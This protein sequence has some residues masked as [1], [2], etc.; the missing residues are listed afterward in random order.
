MSTRG[1]RR[2]LPLFVLGIFLSA[3]FPSKAQTPNTI[4]T[5]A[6]GGANSTSA[7]AA[8]LPG[9]TAAVRDT[10]GNTYV[11]VP[12]LNVVY[13]INSLGQVSI[14][15]GTGL[16]G[17]SGDGG[18]AA[19][20]QLNDPLSL[21]VDHQG[22]LFISDSSNNRIRRVDATTG[23]ITTYAGSGDQYNGV[24]FFGGYSGDDGP[25]TSALLNLPSGLAFDGNE[26]LF[27]ADAGNEV[28]RRI[29]NS[30]QHII[31]TYA[32]N[33]NAGVPGTANGD[34]GPAASAQLNAY[35][36]QI[37]G[38]ATDA[39][40]NLFIADSGDSVVRMVDTS[41]SHIITTYAGS[42]SHTF[43]F[44]GNGGSAN[45]AG[46]NTPMG[47]FVDNAG[48]LLIA[49]TFNGIVRKVDTTPS[50]IITTAVGGSGEC[51]TF[52][53][54][55]GNGGAPTGAALNR[56]YGVFVDSPGNLLIADF[57][58][59]TIRA[60]SPAP[61]SVISTFAGGGN[62][63]LGGAATSALLALPYYV[64][65]DSSGNL[66]VQDYVGVDRFDASSKT[67]GAYAGNSSISGTTFGPGNGDNGPANQ[68]DFVSPSTLALDG[69]GD[70]FVNE[71]NRWV[72][73]VDGATK[74]VTTYA[75][76]GLKCNPTAT[77]GCGDGG[78]AT[79]AT[80][81]NISGMAA[82]SGGNLYVADSAQ[83]RIRRI[84]KTTGVISNYAGTGAA[85][86]SGDN[87]PATSATF[88]TPFG[89][90]FDAQDDLYVADAANNVVRRIDN[91]TQHNITTYAFNGLAAF[92]GDGGTALTAS[93]QFPSQVVLDA[94]GNLF[95]SGG[96]DNVVRRIDQADQTVTTVA[97]DIHNLDG[98]FAGDGGPS[99]QALLSN[100]GVAIDA[101]KNVYIGDAGNNRIRTVHL[102][103]V[104]VVNS[105]LL[106]PFGTILPGQS[107]ASEE[108]TITNTGL[109][110]LA[111]TNITA[112]TN[113]V[114]TNECV[115][116]VTDVSSV[117]PGAATCFLMVTFVAPP[118]ATAGTVFSGN[119]TFSTSDP[120][121]PSF[122]LPVT[123]TVGALPGVTL[124]VTESGGGSGTVVSSP[125]GIVC[126]SSTC[127]ANFALNQQ[128]TLTAIGRS[129][130]ALT[131]WTVN[132]LTTTC[133]VALP[134][135][136]TMSQ[137]QNV[138]ATFSA[139]SMTVAAL[140]NGSGT[141]TSSPAG[142]S[143][144][145]TSGVT[146]GTCTFSG[147]PSGTQTVTL[148]AAP[149][150][151]S[152]FAGWLGF[153]DS[154]GII[155]S[156][157][158]PCQFPLVVASDI[159]LSGAQATAVFSGPVQSFSKGQIF[160]GSVDGMIFVYNPNGTLAQVLNSGNLGGTIAGMNFDKTGNLYAA[161]PTT[162][163]VT[164]GTVEFFGNNGSGPTTFGTGYNSEPI[165]VLVDPAGNVFVGQAADQHSLLEFAGAQNTA[166]SSTFFPAFESAGVAYLD[167]LD[168]NTS[169]LYTSASPSVKN[170]DI[171]HRH[172]NPD[173]ATNLPGGAAYA[174]RELGDKSILV[175]NS[176]RIVR[177]SPS[178]AVLQTYTPVAGGLFYALNLDP[179]GVSYWTGD[180][181]SGKVF[182]I[183]ISDGTVLSTINT[184]LGFSSTS[185]AFST[186]FG[187]AVFGQPQAGGADLSVAMTSSPASVALGAQV[188][189][190]IVVTN[191]GPISAANVAMTD[192]FPAGV[193]F[194]SS[195]TS[196]GTCA[197]TTTV[198][199]TLGTMTSGQNATMTI[200]V[201]LTQ[202]GTLLNTVNV[203]STTPDPNTANNSAGSSTL[204]TAG[205]V[206]TVSEAGSGL[207][208]VSSTPA[209]IT[210]QPN[211]SARFLAGTVVTLTA[212]PSAGSTFAGW[213]GACSGTGSC[214][215][216][217]NAA[218]GVIANFALAS[219]TACSAAGATIWT[220]GASGNWNVGSNWSTGAIP[221][222]SSVNVC[223]NDGNGTHSQV[224][225]T[226]GVSVGSL[227]IDAGSSL[228]ISNNLDFQV[229]GNIY[230]AGTITLNSA[231]NPTFLSVVGSA[232]LSGTGTIAMANP[233]AILREDASG[234]T[235]TNVNN[236][237]A[238]A[239]QVGNNGLAFVN[240]AAGVINANNSGGALVF[241]ASG[242]SNQGLLEASSG[243]TLQVNVGMNNAG[244]NISA[245]TGSTVQLLSGAN[246][247]GGTLT[248]STGAGTFLGTVQSTPVLDGSSQGPLTLV[249]TY[250]LSNNTDTQLLGTINNTNSIFINS[251]GNPT[252]LSVL[253]AVTLTGHGN[254]TMGNPNAIIREDTSGSTLTNFNNT[255]AGAGQVGNNG[256]TFINQAQGVVNA[257]SPGNALLMNASAAV[258]QGL[259]EARAGGVLQI[260]VTVN[261]FQANITADGTN[262]QV[263]LLNGA[264]IEGGTLNLINGAA[265]L[266]TQ[267]ST[268]VLDGSTQGP[269][270]NAGVYTLLNNTD[271]QLVGTIVNSNSIQ[272]SSVG[273]P[274]F[275]SMTGP[276]TLTG[277]GTVNMANQNAII[278]E[279]SSNSTLTN[280]N[281]SFAGAGQLG[282]N[283]LTLINRPAGVVNANINGNALLVNASGAVNQGTFE[284]S[285]P[286]GILEVN[287]TVNN[288]GGLITAASG[289]QVQFLAGA[290]IQG[291]T[292]SSG[293]GPNTFFGTVQSTVVLDGAA[294]GPLTN[295]AVYTLSNNTDTQIVGTIQ[296]TNSLF[297]NSTLNPTFLSAVGAV[298]LTGAGT[299]T[300]A[301]GNA[302]VRQDAAGSTL[303]NVN[304]SIAGAGQIGNNGLV[305][306]NQ[307]GGTMNANSPG[308]ALLFNAS[309]AVNQGALEASAGGVLQINVTVVNASALIFATGATS[310]VQLFNGA[311]IQ[312]GTINTVSGA[313]FLTAQSTVILDGSSSGALTN[314]GTYT[315]SN[316]TDTEMM[317]AISNTGTISVAAAGNPTFLSMNGAVTLSGAGSVAMGGGNAVIRQ[318]VAGSTLTNVNNS[319]AGAGQIGSGG[320]G[321]VN[322]PAGIINAN[323]TSASLLFNAATARNLGL[324]ESSGGGTLQFDVTLN[325]ASGTITAGAGS[326]VQLFGGADIQGGTL[327]SSAAPSTF[328]GTVQST[329][330]LDGAT[331]GPLTNAAFYTLSN[332]TDTQLVGVI[333]NTGTISIAAAGNPTFLSMNGAVTLTGPG[334]VAMAGGNAVIR[335]DV[336]GSSLSNSGNR[337][338][339]PGQFAIPI[340]TQT[341]GFIQIPSGDSDSISTFSISGG[342]AQIDG[343]LSVSG[344]VTTSGTGVVSGT[345][346]IPT[347]VSN[348]GITEAGDIPA[349]GTL[350]ISG[351]HTFT[352]T[353]GGAYEVA[354]GGLTAGSQ[355]SQLN[356]SGSASLAGALNVRFAN[357]FTPVAGNQFIIL[358]ASAVSGTF[359]T[360]NA[361]AVSG[362]TWSLMYS[363]TSVTLIAGG[364]SPTSFTLTV[365]EPGN[366]SGTVTDDLGGINC[367]EAAGVVTGSCSASY[368]SGTVVTLTAAPAAGTTFSGWSTCAGT[369]PCSVTMTSSRSE[370]ATFGAVVP[371]FSIS[372]A[373]LGTGTGSV[374]DNLGAIDCAEA[375]GIVT[376]TC[377]ASYASGTEV[378]LTENATSPTTFGG[379]GNAC[380]TSGTSSTCSLTVSSAL[381]VSANFVPPPASVNVTFAP[382]S[383]VTQQAPFDC[384]SNPNPTPAN[385]CTDP[386]AH[387]LQLQIPTVNT[388]FTVTVT[389]T[390]VPPAQADG[391]CEAG[392][393][394]LDDFDCRFATFFSFGTD[395]HGNTIVPLCYPYANGNCVHYDVYSGTPGTEPNPS[396]Y[397]GGVDWTI[398]WNNGTFL[399]PALYSGTTPQLYDDPDFAPTPTAA[400]G[401][402]CT[403]PMTINGV[404]ESYSCQFEFDITTFF[405]SAGLV[406]PG[407]GGHTKQLNDVVVAFPPNTT[408]QMSVTSTPDAA[409]VN[410]GTPIGITIGVSNAGPGAVNNVSL[411][412]P[413]P[414]GSG[415]NWSISP[416]YSGPGTCSIAGAVGGQ[417]LSCSFG[418]FASGANASL[419][420][421]SAF[422]GAG[423]YVNSATVT[424]GNHQFLTIATIIV[425]QVA[426]AFSGLTP[427]QAVTAGTASITLAGT[428]SAAGPVFPASA[429][430]VSVTING[431][432]KPAT[433]GASG[434]FSV[435]FPTAT[436]PA[437]A[438]P[439]TITY[440]YAGDGNLTLATNTGTTLTVNATIGNST[441]TITELGS[442]TGS[443]TDNTGRISCSEA[444]G[445]VSGTCSASYPAGTQ[446]LLTENATAPS[447]FG[448]WTNAC[449]SSGTASTCGLTVSSNLTA[450][451]N[452]I[453]PPASVNFTFTPGT[454][455]AQQG[456]FNCPSNPNPS[457]ANPCTAPNA[458][459]LQLQ[460]PQ[461]ITPFT[462][463]LVATEVPPSQEDG[464]CEVGHTVANDFDCRFSTFFNFG[465]DASGNTIVPLCDPYANGNCVH[466][467][468]FSGTPGTEPD[469]SFYTGP[470]SWNIT[471][472]NGA[473][474]PPAPYAGSTPR[475][476][477]DPDYAP[478]PTSAVGSVCGQP[479]TINGLPQSYS[480]QFEFDITTFFETTGLV[481]PG[482]G[483]HTKQLN[484]V[485]V[486][487][488]PTATGGQL[489]STSASS[490][491]T[492]GSPISFTI[493]ITNRGPGSE[494]SVTL[495]DPLPDVSSSSWAFSPAFTGPGTCLINGAAGAQTLSCAFGNLPAGTN[496]TIGVTNP[497]AAAGSYTNTATISASNQQVLSI[498]SATI[499]AFATSFSGLTA[500][501]SI[502]FGTASISLSGV[503]SA[504]GPLFPPSGETVSVSINGLTRTTPVGASGAFSLTFPTATVP[505]VSAPYTIT[506]SFAADSKFAATTNTSTTLRV[507]QASQT[508]TFAG[509]PATAT[510]GSSFAVSAAASS[511]LTVAITASGACAISSG[512]VTMTSGTG[513]C[514]LAANQAGNS[515]Y[516]PAP[517]VT[518]ATTAQKAGSS[519][520]VSSN[521][522]NP[523]N[524]GQTVA[525]GVKVSGN[526]TATGSVQ[527]S[528]STGETCAAMLV[529]AAGT[530]SITFTTSGSRTLTAV[531]SGDN[532]FNG[533]TSAGV[534]QTVNASA[535]P[536]V[537]IGSQLGQ[538]IVG[539]TAAGV[540]Q[541]TATISLSNSGNVGTSLQVTSATLNG[542]NSSSVPI[543]LSLAPSSTANVALNFPAGAGASGTHVVLIVKGT[544]STV[545]VGG[546]TLTGSWTGSFRVVLPSS[547]P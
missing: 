52:T 156:G 235:L 344:G 171:V 151:S 465:T 398:K 145:V 127:T 73:R 91:T 486:A 325:N 2:I 254:V 179:D 341:A 184:G 501:Q 535:P 408:G 545:V 447:T 249:G 207:G 506:Y 389:A 29:D 154:G 187:I 449:A 540:Q 435:V 38:L 149:T 314:A 504:P 379:W 358:K 448:G 450:T 35:L 255:L 310:S 492:P 155:G 386:N 289:S 164:G 42:S 261:N 296:N 273:N 463:T 384:P 377:S 93:M 279:D 22:N 208:S 132:G 482:I 388:G 11:A 203:T 128:V 527:V 338:T 222:G 472:N 277:S 281:N 240:Q 195:A 306:T 266:G 511:G 419:H 459:T 178:G 271:T 445:V 331:N 297:I 43:T 526:G 140:G 62:T 298:T 241:N 50:H 113:F 48:N 411:D 455:V 274:T 159:A 133:S 305:V 401:T 247:Q 385:P 74:T 244:G 352:Q 106:Q 437:S 82:D 114:V 284:S 46:L 136:V 39:N 508:I 110:D 494:S 287:V 228:S 186:I 315:L 491:S 142:I 452:F 80:F 509:G 213:S 95:V 351:A 458:H 251:A 9:T 31:T 293:T 60:V 194:V 403:Q 104:A 231:G 218:A 394:V 406:D 157:T 299:V 10:L 220:G 206:L 291:G 396:F 139:A 303:T 269:L 180:A 72:R 204:V 350:A 434:T 280:V 285:A 290:R 317:G 21:A 129:G 302:V 116:P 137:A 462:I 313:S 117:S 413:L 44:S 260:N 356:V 510:Y 45:Q 33:G 143:C 259:F 40:G 503:V 5:L 469:P 524:A 23:D 516:N 109:D 209:A 446:V 536:V 440:S 470:V 520:V 436:I 30:A 70:L 239:G 103:P 422:A 89:L 134:C 499:Q 47:L 270:T 121:N 14:Y 473:F 130:S 102:A 319:I 248:A 237:I 120:A 357:G 517:Q 391:L 418:S 174:I 417:D 286:G 146:S 454:N 252:F 340:F 544:Y 324:I 355:Y 392:N 345:G 126:N 332:N 275:L 4:S 234:S 534:S 16:A 370:Q 304:N 432:T 224:T 233:N 443:I 512:T 467:A 263:Q 347:N 168:D 282:N 211:C 12:P 439:Y 18:P 183:R 182:H 507:T 141:I 262:S 115:N 163:G 76:T 6:G 475:L 243:G 382:G 539:R 92:G 242:A 205:N 17:F 8:N 335:Q 160:V 320:L 147:F 420:I 246:I 181:S 64:V 177:L 253:G 192:A 170:F 105:S 201:S 441:L 230:N 97:G 330:L 1:L 124:T 547:S 144:T 27:V 185:L 423:T 362:V 13:K 198:T 333:N 397:G 55:C 442:G 474:V 153:C 245:A 88:H 118:A 197:G 25:A 316:N 221:N 478:T 199:C 390:E 387:L 111:I 495:N 68:A 457:P 404:T 349:A 264:R 238:G 78:P 468:V 24:G 28:V 265:F 402:V 54:G 533:S 257:N 165:G 488:P 226:S 380:A 61:S 98:G 288:L 7:T 36:N 227:T 502:T 393:T 414:S 229:N 57:G 515:N 477:D 301:N 20:A 278:R 321:F 107:S 327:T 525:I 529:S 200:V 236:T 267:Q 94:N 312:G 519:T 372:V 162:T 369:T 283:G 326:S 223:I 523:S 101:N 119:L 471:W 409:S 431:V 538:L 368:Q 123:A 530:C 427:S 49:D 96:M 546:S 484:D 342:N 426:P 541:Y 268:V 346:S 464:L 381:S 460:L 378:I 67:L 365:T 100:F 383:N 81:V 438:T 337:I 256:L 522:P 354:L 329:V 353:S 537:I 505:A 498:S 361:P 58:D 90:A 219:T 34:G 272:V 334:S 405:D 122:S 125:S 489:T 65:G 210:C 322:Q 375:N 373:E 225:L 26:N 66:F 56:P 108:V 493:S 19:S 483:G 148:T 175:A 348:A 150:G 63:T 490:S 99:T 376:G 3:A 172:Q 84:D 250:T 53:T 294:Q 339:G 487:F 41:A 87:G 188:T 152:T 480:C 169:V 85:G 543:S 215:V 421:T 138:T 191:N 318:D 528:A 131:G 497:T 79:S 135:T 364:G 69:S 307:P 216:T 451:G 75:G 466:Y 86:D 32:G 407:I 430:T 190:T 461:V 112:P 481:D 359:S 276:V 295:A 196:L 161:N 166:P 83:N 416:A 429:E 400:V 395:S 485:V 212:A 531:Y 311:R 158:G 300:M 425:Q 399:P 479:M 328:F 532:N 428:V 37:M 424:A 258:N 323:N 336:S 202:A 15:A 214:V 496:F 189:Y 173:L 513:T 363:A 500:S 193:K 59:G 217:M 292:L 343:S 444:N 521:V 415:V 476:Y 542:V 167:L 366:G 71:F 309:N 374:T 371:T 367:V 433:I 453:P 232:S 514:L 518:A 456:I 77:P 360:I 308:N 412:D 410:A 176:T 51:L